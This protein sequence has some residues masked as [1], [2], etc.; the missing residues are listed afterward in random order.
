[1]SLLHESQWINGPEDL[2][3][4]DTEDAIIDWIYGEGLDR[5][6]YQVR[7]LLEVSS[8][9]ESLVIDLIEG[10][11]TEITDSQALR[12][13]SSD[14]F[15]GYLYTLAENKYRSDPAEWIAKWRQHHNEAQ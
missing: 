5:I 13:A 15:E 3:Y 2:H 6:E 12:I 14:D 7:F 4:E 1:M 11:I 8:D 10:K 9:F